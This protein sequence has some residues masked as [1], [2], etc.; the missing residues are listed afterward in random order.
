MVTQIDSTVVEYLLNCRKLKY[1]FYSTIKNPWLRTISAMD[2]ISPRRTECDETDFLLFEQSI[3]LQLTKF[4][5]H[6]IGCFGYANYTCNNT[7]LSWGTSI[8]CLF[9]ESL[10]IQVNPLILD[11]IYNDTNTRLGLQTF[12]EFLIQ[13][14]DPDLDAHLRDY[15]DGPDPS[16]FP[17]VN[18]RRPGSTTLGGTGLKQDLRIKKMFAWLNSC[19][20]FVTLQGEFYEPLYSVYDWLNA[21]QKM[22]NTVLNLSSLECRRQAASDTLREIISEVVEKVKLKNV[23]NNDVAM[24]MT[25]P[26][27]NLY[28]LLKS[29]Y[30]YKKTLSDL[31][32]FKELD[33][34]FDKRLNSVL[35]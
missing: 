8:S 28:S 30:P 10:G 14:Q 18:S 1:K 5:S 6:D 12:T 4:C 9:L 31:Y 17:L 21:E 24:I 34:L 33:Y 27:D 15:Y 16:T 3:D 2:I 26:C 32:D 29:Y 13:L 23:C 7:H 20:Q 35:N 25:Y 11:T 19:T 22:Y